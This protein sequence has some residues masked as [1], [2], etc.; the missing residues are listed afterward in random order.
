MLRTKK[1]RAAFRKYLLI[2]MIV[3]VILTSLVSYL[4]LD[5][6]NIRFLGFTVIN[7]VT[8]VIW[9]TIMMEIVNDALSKDKLTDFQ[10]LRQSCGSWA[11]A[12]GGGLA[13]LLSY[14]QVEW[15]ITAVTL[16]CLGTCV[17]AIC[18]YKAYLQLSK[19]T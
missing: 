13:V 16:Q 2:V 12:C 7:S 17:F 14:L 18:D 15:I 8:V 3:D 11:T 6:A 4:S 5:N 9:V 10:V 19:T 1:H